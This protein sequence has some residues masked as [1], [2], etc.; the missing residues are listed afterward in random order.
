MA[1]PLPDPIK[2]EPL[3]N[4]VDDNP[5][6]RLLTRTARRLRPTHLITGKLY[7]G[8]PF[9][10]DEWRDLDLAPIRAHDYAQALWAFRAAPPQFGI[11][12]RAVRTAFL[13]ALIGL[14]GMFAFVSPTLAFLA[15]LYIIIDLVRAGDS[16]GASHYLVPALMDLVHELHVKDVTLPYTSKCTLIQ[17]MKFYLYVLAAGFFFTLTKVLFK[18]LPNG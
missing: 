8:F 2:F 3:L 6:Y 5:V 13:L 11:K 12:I 17:S 18:A 15:S 1:E 4:G 7:R 16:L 9:S 14:A 10:P